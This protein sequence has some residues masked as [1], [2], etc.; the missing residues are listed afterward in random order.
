[1]RGR[2][3]IVPAGAMRHGILAW[4]LAIGLVGCGAEPRPERTPPPQ[5]APVT[6]VARPSAEAPGRARSAILIVVDSLRADMLTAARMPRV[7]RWASEGVS[8]EGRSAG[9]WS[10]P[11]VAT[12]LTTVHPDR[13]HLG[14]SSS[15]LPESVVTL[16]EA[17]RCHDVETA[18]FIAN[19]YISDPFGFSQGW[20]EHV[21]V[22]R[23]SQPSSADAMVDRALAWIAAHGTKRFFLYLHLI[24]PHD[25]YSP[26]GDLLPA[27]GLNDPHPYAT[28]EWVREVQAGRVTPTPE[29]RRWIRRLYEAEV[30]FADRELG[31]FL[32][33]L[34]E[35]DVDDDTLVVLTSDNGEHLGEDGHYGHALD[36]P[37]LHEVP[38]VFVGPG[39]PA[40][41]AEA[42]PHARVAPTIVAALGF[43]QPARFEAAPIGRA[44][45]ERSRRYRY[46]AATPHMGREVCERL[47]RLGYAPVHGCEEPASTAPQQ[48]EDP[49]ETVPEGPGV[50]DRVRG[51]P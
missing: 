42:V 12:L 48:G 45:Q 1:M 33:R 37:L 24:D 21:N 18:S 51:L 44:F 47:R 16:A 46:D 39:A 3:T 15:R 34:S 40:A 8:F 27:P 19:G 31:R 43:E 22:I 49:C 2:C 38:L 30:R 29:Q 9:Y 6:R 17:L 41:T 28:A 14:D 11:S 36:V 7:T 25:P 23:E 32:A 20:D 13:L 5:S 50:F 10:K 35:L 4:L 26:P